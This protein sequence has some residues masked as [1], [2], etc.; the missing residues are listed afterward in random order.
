MDVNIKIFILCHKAAY[1][2]EN[3]LLRPVQV[4]CANSGIHLENMLHDDDGEN[5][6]EKNKSYCELTGQYWAWKHEDADY[7]GFFHYRRYLA[8]NSQLEPNDGWGNVVYDRITDDVLKEIKLQEDVMQEL[9]CS[10]DLITVRG[11]DYRELKKIGEMMTVYKEYDQSIFQHKKDLDLVLNIIKEDYPEYLEAAKEYMNSTHAYECNMF[12]MKKEM[13]HAYAEWLFAILFKAEKEINLETYSREECRVI[14]FLGERLF[15]IYYTWLKKKQQVKCLELPKTL[16]LTTDPRS[17]IELA[18]E[19][20]IPII[21]SANDRFAP[22]LDVMIRSVIQHASKSR[23]Y[24]III[25]YND[26]TENSQKKIRFS[27]ENLSNVSIRFIKV[28]EYFDADKLFVNQHL[29]VETYY[30]L[31][32]PE[33]MPDYDKVLYLDCDMVVERDVAE[34]YDLE[35]ADFALAAAKDIDIAGS[36]KRDTLLETYVTKKLGLK[37]PYEYFQAGVLLISLNR[38]RNLA[39]SKKLIELALSNKW[40]CHDQDVLNIICKGHVLFLPQN[41]NVLMNWHNN[42]QERMDILKMAP[43]EEFDNYLSVRNHPDIVHFAGFQ[44]PWDVPDCDMA[45]YFWKYAR[46]SPYYESIITGID[47]GY[48][49]RKKSNSICSSTKLRKVANRLF[50]V[51]TRRRAMVRSVVNMRVKL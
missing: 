9:I 23:K 20:G 6:S 37:N 24:D 2:P 31:I 43:A 19:D 22:Y 21:L 14:G 26:I 3:N 28:K 1:I 36:I 18:F 41:W 47:A 10:Y 50:P 32:I 49:N 27:H 11:R 5:I 51:G 7:Y 38:L 29:S 15:G 42:G 44:K 12:I 40:R 17:K 34:L 8:F 16:F 13:F 45:E 39:D 25:L 30:R 4:G 48:Q 46:L 33:I 35:L